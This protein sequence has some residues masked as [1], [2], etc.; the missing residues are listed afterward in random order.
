MTIINFL[1]VYK[2]MLQAIYVDDIKDLR[3]KSKLN[4]WVPLNLSI[5]LTPQQGGSGIQEAFVQVDLYVTCNH[6]YP[7]R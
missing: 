4:K 1:F 6:D 2:K 5:T 3:S 7:I